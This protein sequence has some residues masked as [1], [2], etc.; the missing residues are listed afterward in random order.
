MLPLED[1]SLSRR[2]ATGLTWLLLAVVTAPQLVAHLHPEEFVAGRAAAGVPTVHP[3][4]DCHTHTL[5]HA[6]S[7]QHCLC[8]NLRKETALRVAS[9]FDAES[10]VRADS[11]PAVPPATYRVR[12]FSILTPPR[13]PP[14]V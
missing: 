8:H 6:P 9:W 11:A 7:S 1:A 4:S 12:L 13:A 3:T 10:L 2:F 14:Q 5:P